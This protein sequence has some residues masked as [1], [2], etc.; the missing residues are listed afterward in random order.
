M[1]ILLIL[2]FVPLILFNSCEELDI[3]TSSEFVVNGIEKEFNGIVVKKLSY[4]EDVQEVQ[5]VLKNGD[6]VFTSNLSVIQNLEIGDSLIKRSNDNIIRV[7]SGNELKFESTFM[8][9]SERVRNSVYFPE[10]WKKK[11]PEA[12][13]DH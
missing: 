12:T 5:A 2:G 9:I 4:R 8:F 1:R 7:Y 3:M 13:Y 6:T 10:E 11:W